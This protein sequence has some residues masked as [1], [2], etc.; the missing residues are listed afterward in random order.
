M[1]EYKVG[2]KVEHRWHGTMEVTYG[3]Y[4]DTL[5]G[6][7]YLVRLGDSEIPLPAE[8][9]SPPTT[10]FAV[11]DKVRYGGMLAEIIGGPVTGADTGEEIVLF[12]YLEGPDDGKGRRR[13]VSLLESITEPALVLVGTRV[14]VDRATY[15]EHTHGMVGVVTSSSETFRSYEG[16]LHP[17][18]VELGGVE[19]DVYAAEVTPVVDKPADGFEYEGVFYEYG[20][21]Y[22]DREGDL[23][24]F[25]SR[26]SDD[27]TDT[28]EGRIDFAAPDDWNWSLAEVV[29]NYGPIVKQ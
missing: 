7:R 22:Q 16:D 29:R 28:P 9:L 12:K 14:R 13:K 11:G 8:T 19:G 2:E 4:T 26:R 21:L 17:Y 23:F 3:P 20:A 1:S 5:G 27:G 10:K 15:G 18:R 6:T 24:K 25:R